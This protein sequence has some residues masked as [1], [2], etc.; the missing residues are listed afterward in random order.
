MHLRENPVER[1]KLVLQGNGGE[2]WSDSIKQMDGTGPS[3]W[4]GTRGVGGYKAILPT[5]NRKG[6]R[7]YVFKAGGW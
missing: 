3:T 6:G 2:G 5:R 7:I 1:G 4:S